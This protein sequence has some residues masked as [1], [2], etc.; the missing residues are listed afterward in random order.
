M[1]CLDVRAKVGDVEAC[2]ALDKVADGLH[3]V[4]IWS[5]VWGR[6]AHA[7]ALASCAHILCMTYLL[8]VVRE[9]GWS[10]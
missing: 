1:N 3:G 4:G 2:G 7:H 10:K 5:T 9:S 8:G 6:K